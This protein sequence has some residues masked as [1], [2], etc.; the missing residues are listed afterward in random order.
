MAGAIRRR[1]AAATLLAGGAI[2]VMALNATGTA[3]D[4]FAR[5]A[6]GVADDAALATA[7]TPARRRRR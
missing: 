4:T 5:A 6:T 1:V 7:R 3:A 2:G